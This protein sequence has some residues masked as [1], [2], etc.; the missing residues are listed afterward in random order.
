MFA[1]HKL[2]RLLAP[3]LGTREAGLENHGGYTGYPDHVANHRHELA[4]AQ[5]ER[6]KVA[7]AY[8]R[9]LRGGEAALHESRNYEGDLTPKF[10]PREAV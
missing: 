2:S 6:W 9:T 10:T 1:V 8:T 3:A 7:E 4:C 5:Y